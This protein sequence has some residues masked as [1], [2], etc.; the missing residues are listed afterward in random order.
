M[1]DHW[2]R[3]RG[4]DFLLSAFSAPRHII[5][6]FER[7]TGPVR[8]CATEPQYV[9]PLLPA[10]QCERVS[11]SADLKFTRAEVVSLAVL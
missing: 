8:P 11:S 2:H 6:M 9:T 1:E 7:R 5:R 3:E 4:L 10:L